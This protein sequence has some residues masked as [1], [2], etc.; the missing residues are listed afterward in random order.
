MPEQPDFFALFGI[1]PTLT[2]DAAALRKKFYGLSRQYHPDRFSSQDAAAQTEALA[3]TARL[4]EAYRTLSHEELLLGYVL[5]REGVLQ[6]EEHYQLPA[7]FLME[8]MEL[9]EQ[10]SEGEEGAQPLADAMAEWERGMAPLRVRYEQ[11]ER[12]AELL[13]AMKDYY[14]RKKYLQRIQ[15]RLA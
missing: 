4:N 12:S 7:E 13:A 10:L 14:F 8:M 5:R 11:G 1:A 6:D 2:T 9:N 15:G 3:M